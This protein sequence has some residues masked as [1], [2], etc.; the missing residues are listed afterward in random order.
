M[1]TYLN[2]CWVNK[3]GRTHDR[4]EF[5]EKGQINTNNYQESFSFF[6]FYSLGEANV[7]I[8]APQNNVHHWQLAIEILFVSSKFIRIE[9]E[10]ETPNRKNNTFPKSQMRNKDKLSE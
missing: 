4:R 8:K 1:P 2:K 5:A 3:H 7:L 6:S 10:I 9:K